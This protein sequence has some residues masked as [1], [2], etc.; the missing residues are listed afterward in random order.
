M[1]SRLDF[2]LE[3]LGSNSGPSLVEGPPSQ[4]HSITVD[5]QDFYFI[6]LGSLPVCRHLSAWRWQSLSTVEHLPQRMAKPSTSESKLQQVQNVRAH[7]KDSR[8]IHVHTENVPITLD[9]RFSSPKPC[10]LDPGPCCCRNPA[11][12]THLNPKP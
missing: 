3:T 5:R 11:S 6:T 4:D 1:L 2:C 7:R 9:P 8:L 10:S 12:S